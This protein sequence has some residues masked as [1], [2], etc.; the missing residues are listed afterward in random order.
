MLDA[1]FIQ[2]SNKLNGSFVFLY[3]F[4][5]IPVLSYHVS[6]KRITIV[7]LFDPNLKE[8]FVWFVTG[9]MT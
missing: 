4:L 2:L 5:L 8:Y 9:E 3:Y 6:Q 7:H 1:F